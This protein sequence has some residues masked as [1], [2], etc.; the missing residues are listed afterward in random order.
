MCDRHSGEYGNLCFDCFE[1]LVRLG[2]KTDIAQFMK[3][4]VPKDRHAGE[5]AAFSYFDRIFPV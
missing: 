2:V 1:E 4:D 3:S 5:D